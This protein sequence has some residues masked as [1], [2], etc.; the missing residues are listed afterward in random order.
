MNNLLLKK[1]IL[2]GGRSR[3]L[4]KEREGRGRKEGWLGYA[5]NGFYKVW[6]E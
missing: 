6:L 1:K 5:W 2:R 4:M 3:D